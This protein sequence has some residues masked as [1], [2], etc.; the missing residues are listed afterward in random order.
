MLVHTRHWA[1]LPTG[2][3]PQSLDAA[4]DVALALHEAVMGV[5]D[6]LAL[7]VQVG[8]GAGA[9]LLRLVGE[10]LAGLEALGAAVEAV[11]AGEQLLALLEV[12]VGGA[13]GVVGVAGAEEGGAVRGEVGELAA[14][15]VDVGL[16]VAEALVDLA[17]GRRG[18]VGLFEAHLADSSASSSA[19]SAWLMAALRGSPESSGICSIFCD[20]SAWTSLSSASYELK[21]SEPAS[22][23]RGFDMAGDGSCGSQGGGGGGGDELGDAVWPAEAT[24]KGD[25]A[26]GGRGAPRVGSIGTE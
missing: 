25:V 23:S 11:G 22:L 24:E 21:S 19:R 14:A 12:D 26:V 20:R 3:A 15:A 17:A 2:H 5:L 6:G 4:V 18:D 1:T 16:V 7:A 9:N 8:E 10:G 13:G